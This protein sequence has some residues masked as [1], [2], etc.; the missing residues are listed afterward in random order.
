MKLKFPAFLLAW[1][2]LLMVT[3][4]RSAPWRVVRQAAPNPLEGKKT[5]ALAPISFRGLHVGETTEQDYLAEKSQETRQKWVGDKKAI[6][7]TFARTLV[8]EAEEAGIEIDPMGSGSFT[9]HPRVAWLEPGFHVGM[10]KKSSKV[11]LTF[12]I[13][14]RDGNLIDHVKLTHGSEGYTIRGRLEDDAEALASRVA[15]Y[16]QGRVVGEDG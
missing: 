12:V 11:R 14:D 6:N 15:D 1:M 16:L 3:G 4:C 5:F 9:I 2:V 8:A 13:I 7:A 10:A